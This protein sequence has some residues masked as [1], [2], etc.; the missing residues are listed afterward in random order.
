M[1]DAF[2]SMT[3]GRI[4]RAAM[5]IEHTLEE[6]QQLRGTQFCPVAVEALISGLQMDASTGHPLHQKLPSSQ[7]T[8]VL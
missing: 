5:S 8:G 6:L 3:T 1:A 4:Y 2:D 7:P